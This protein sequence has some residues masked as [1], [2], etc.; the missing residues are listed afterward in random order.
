MREDNA[1]GR[2]K[3]V[4]LAKILAKEVRTDRQRGGDD[5][6]RGSEQGAR[7]GAHCIRD[8]RSAKFAC[9]GPI[10]A[11]KAAMDLLNTVML[12]VPD[13]VYQGNYYRWVLG[14]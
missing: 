6:A 3:V 8:A 12:C 13:V 4:V 1:D 7:C 9:H 14:G 11:I 5:D 10:L 2:R